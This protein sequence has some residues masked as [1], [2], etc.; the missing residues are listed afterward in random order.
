MADAIVSAS[1]MRMIKLL[2]GNP[3][4]SISEL[5]KLLAVTRTAVTEQLSELVHTGFV[6]RELDP[7]RG[8]GRPQFVYKATNAASYI[9]YAVNQCMVVPAMWAAV[10]D[11][12]GNDLSRKVLKKVGKSLAEH[13][14]HK[15]T[16]K[17]PDERLRQLSKLMNAEGGL[18]QAVASGGHVTLHKRSC[19]FLRMAD[20]KFTICC[21]DLEMM[22]LIVGK[23][24]RR[25]ACRHEGSPCCSFEIAE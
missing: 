1:G 16:A 24:V 17:K 6:E 8:R 7:V 25:I 4:R 23:P 21:V 22:S 3:P 5:A 19:P 9:L 20:E 10:E 11:I 14:M 15:V 18:T 2:V 12:G 13:Y